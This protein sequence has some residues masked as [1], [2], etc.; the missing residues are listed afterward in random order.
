MITYTC[1]R[2]CVLVKNCFDV[3]QEDQVFLPPLCLW[4]RFKSPA[5]PKVTHLIC[6]R[7]REA[8]VYSEL[9]AC[10]ADLSAIKEFSPA[11]VILSPLQ[12][13]TFLGRKSFCDSGQGQFDHHELMG[14]V[15]W[16]TQILS[17][18][19]RF[20]TELNFLVGK[21]LQLHPIYLVT[22]KRIGRRAS[23]RFR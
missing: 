7:I 17:H 16:R 12:Q 2:T 5:H 11:G 22:M 15:A 23:R 9:Q 18:F 1:T 8:S 3:Q 4:D 14:F 21:T 13:R 6:R 20:C 19:S 10:T